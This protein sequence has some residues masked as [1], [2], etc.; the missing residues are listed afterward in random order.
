MAREVAG[1]VVHNCGAVVAV[2]EVAVA[3][4]AGNEAVLVA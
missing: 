4:V 2:A 3:E 1:D